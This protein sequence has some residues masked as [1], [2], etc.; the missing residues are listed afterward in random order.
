MNTETPVLLIFFNRPD[1]L[2]ETFAA[3]RDAKP[4]KLYLAQDGPRD[5]RKDDI[6]AIT[7]CRKIVEKIDWECE[8]HRRYLTKNVGCG[9]GPYQAISWAFETEDRLIIMEDDCVASESFFHFCDEMLEKYEDDNRI[10]MITGCNMELQTRNV[11][12]SYF[13]GYSGTNWGW[14]TWKRN[15][16]MMD[17]ECSFVDDNQVAL[18]LPEFLR[19]LSGRKGKREWI[20]FQD[21]AKRLHNGENISYWD[22]QWQSIRYLN[23]QL[24][25][26]PSKNLITNIGIGPTSTHAKMV[27]MADGYYSKVGKV[28]FNN[29]QRFELEFPL[30]HPD[31]IIQNVEYDR[32][33]DKELDK[34]LFLR[35][36]RRLG[37][38]GNRIAK[39]L[40]SACEN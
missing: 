28:N 24:S 1:T 21:T 18:F 9:L 40:K 23:H 15:W 12:A 31:Y 8:V 19:K 17:Y 27:D 4:T 29:N 35:L 39:T 26:I 30:I 6:N 22:V 14:A 32:K 36:S 25:I 13:F 16:S 10:F 33:I 34:P 2:K 37:F 20:S 11:K 38:I 3:I 7:E 5:G